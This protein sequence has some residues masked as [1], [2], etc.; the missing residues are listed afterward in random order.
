[1]SEIEIEGKPHFE[2]KEAAEFFGISL[3]CLNDWTKKGVLTAYKVE[4]RTYYKRSECYEV[5][6]NTKRA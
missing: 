4:R 5:L 6:F 2:R 1:M 3:N